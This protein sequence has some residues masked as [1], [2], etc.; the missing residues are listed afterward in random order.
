MTRSEWLRPRAKPRKM[1]NWKGR[2]FGL[3]RLVFGR[4]FNGAWV[5]GDGYAKDRNPAI[6]LKREA[7]R[8]RA[9][10]AV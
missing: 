4:A 2:A 5:V 10:R 7:R 1:P 9:R 3:S 6:S 8:Q